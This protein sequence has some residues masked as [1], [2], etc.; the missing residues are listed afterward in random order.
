M[1]SWTRS[2]GQAGTVRD[3]VALEAGTFLLIAVEI[4]QIEVLFARRRLTESIDWR[5]EVNA[6]G[7]QALETGGRGCVRIWG[8][9]RTICTVP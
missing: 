9:V 1:D 6:A 2:A 3:V 7:T 4:F 5:H 8:R